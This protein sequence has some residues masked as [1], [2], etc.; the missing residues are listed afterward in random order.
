MNVTIEKITP[1]VAEGMLNANTSNR[2]LRDGVVE[3]YAADMR[4]GRWTECPMPIVFYEDGDLADGQHRLFAV[5]ESDTTQTFSVYRGLP[6]SAGL[7]IDMGLNRSLVDN[8]RISG[9]G[10]PGLSA[11]MVAVA[12]ACEAGQ[13]PGPRLSN[14]AKMEIVAAH[15]EAVTWAVANGPRC[16]GIRNAIVLAAVARAW[17]HEEDHGRLRR[18]CDVLGTGMADGE[19][20]SAAVA[21]RNYMLLRST[22][23]TTTG[24][25]T[26]TFRKV[27]NA[28]YYFMRTKKLSVIKAVGE[29]VYARPRR[30]K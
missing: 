2:A 28:I 26:D 27:Q 11:E 14:A 13:P 21:L 12:R 1:K 9:K 4:A 20:E 24:M 30:R 29:E 22:I 8:A 5:I 16:K 3:S 23:T 6:R 18:F 19:A 10:L 15:H 17:Y 25:W 7:N